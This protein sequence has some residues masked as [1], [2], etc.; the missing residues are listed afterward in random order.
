M[1]QAGKKDE[2]GPA[3]REIPFFEGMTNH[4]IMRTFIALTGLVL[5]VAILFT[6]CTSEKPGGLPLPTPIDTFPITTPVTTIGTSPVPATA[7]PLTTPGQVDLSIRASPEKYSPLMSSTVGI[8]L[9]PQYSGSAA[10]VYSWNTS[11]GY[12]ISWNATDSKVTP[13]NSSID[14]SDPTIYWSYSPDDMGK[15]KPPVTVRLIVKTPP[16]T[17]GGGG[18]FAWKDLQISWENTDTAVITEAACGIQNCHGMEIS[19]GKNIAEMCTMEYQLGDKCRSLA[20]CQNVNGSCSVVK[21]EGYTVCM[22]CV[23]ECNKTSGGDPAK[24]FACES[25]C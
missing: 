17:H 3:F 11:Y 7:V 6:G 16:R 19:C 8:G 15:E 2:T 14:T 24:A 4:L 20:S 25:R 10:A 21:Q 23:E 5:I 18:T 1:S 12:F 22:S 13:Y 9:T